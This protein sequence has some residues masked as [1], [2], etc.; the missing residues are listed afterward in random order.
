[1]AMVPWTMAARATPRRLLVSPISRHPELWICLRC[2]YS[3]STGATPSPILSKLRE[4]LKT[5]MR[6]RD[7]PRLS[8]LRTL[9]ADITNST[10]T[11][12][13]IQDDLALLSLL[14]KRIASSKAAI[15]EFYQ[16]DRKDLVTK[17]QEQVEILEGYASGVK[18]LD[19]EEVRSAVKSVMDSIRSD[20]RTLAMGDVLKRTLGPGGALEG[21]P[22]Q[23]GEVARIVKEEMSTGA[24]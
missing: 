18:T 19:V 5:S 4:D 10:K 8:V 16:A 12:S 7:A 17:E 23:K 13:P 24:S 2:R 14:K 9:L 3:T 11:S 22:I 21:R 6:A 1:M 15:E 20:G